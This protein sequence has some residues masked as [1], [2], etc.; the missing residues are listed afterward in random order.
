MIK[1][2]ESQD[3]NEASIRAVASTAGLCFI[4]APHATQKKLKAQRFSPLGLKLAEEEH[5]QK[6]DDLH[7]LPVAQR[8]SNGQFQHGESPVYAG[9]AANLLR[10]GNL[11]HAV[12]RVALGLP[13]MALSGSRGCSS[14]GFQT[15]KVFRRPLSPH[16]KPCSCTAAWATNPSSLPRTRLCAGDAFV[17]PNAGNNLPA[18]SKRSAAVGRSG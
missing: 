11:L 18:N 17:K 4:D 13:R 10:V 1:E 6:D 14:G 5:E 16:L 2:Q 15:Y 12:A 9:S 8:Q 7:Q 3:A